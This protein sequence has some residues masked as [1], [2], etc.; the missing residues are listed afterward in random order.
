MRRVSDLV[1]LK[2]DDV[3]GKTHLVI[4]EQK[5]KKTKRFLIP[6][7]T[8]ELIENYTRDMSPANTDIQI[9]V[10]AVER[11]IKKATFE[12]DANLHK[13]LRAAAA[14]EECTMLDIVDGA[15]KEYLDKLNR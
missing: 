13:C 5:T 3:R 1:P 8:K 4:T 9:C 2:V 15:L 14:L 11:K 6:R 12:L 10:N 7:A